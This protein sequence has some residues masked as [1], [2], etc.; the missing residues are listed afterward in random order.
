MKRELTP[1]QAKFIAEYL[2]D[3]NASAAA[4][5]AGYSAKFSNSNAPKLLQN[6]AIAAALTAAQADL[7][8]RVEVTQEQVAARFRDIAFA[9]AR[10]LT[11]MRRGCCRWCWGVDFRYQ[12]TAGEMERARVEWAALPAKQRGARRF[13][14]QG[15]IGFNPTRPAHADCPE[16]FGQGVERPHVNDTRTVS[17]AAAKLFAGVKVTKEGI[18]VKT[19]SQL[20]ALTQLGRHLGMFTDKTKVEHSGSVSLAQALGALNDAARGK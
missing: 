6:P 3:L 13:D 2:V 17:A 16:C 15:G 9:D 5:R 10:E 1:K 18:E 12:R 11:E 4:V 7:A 19:H 14:E 8:K 20:D